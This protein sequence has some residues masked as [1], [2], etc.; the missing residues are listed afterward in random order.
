MMDWYNDVFVIILRS[1][2]SVIALFIISRLT[3]ER[4]ISQLTYYDYIV[5]I[6]LGSIAAMAVENSI[7]LSS[8]VI[9]MIVFGAFT[10]LVAFVTTKSIVLRRLLTG[11]PTVMI[12][13]G[14]IIKKSLNKHHYDINDLLLECRLKGYFDISQIQCAVME[15]NGQMS[16]LP[17]P[18]YNTVTPKD[19]KMAVDNE[20]MQYNLII[21][22]NIMKRILKAYGKDE[23]WLK[24]KLKE[25]KVDSIKDV[26]LCVGDNSDNISIFLQNQKTPHDDFFI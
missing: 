25:Q 16:I 4:Q 6:T 7:S 22:G 9:S 12:Y 24:N 1:V 11:K 14:K 21:D 10:I 13:N 17:K 18:E 19:L 20:F 15:T 26:L 23:I 2:L 8:I 3:G 5:G